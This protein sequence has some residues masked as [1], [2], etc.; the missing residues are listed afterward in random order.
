MKRF[1][2]LLPK[3]SEGSP[4]TPPEPVKSQPF[5]KYPWRANRRDQQRVREA[6]Q[7]GQ[8]TEA[9]DELLG[10]ARKHRLKTGW[11]W[12]L[13]IGPS[14]CREWLS[15][16]PAWVPR[17]TRGG[18]SWPVCRL[19]FL[20][21]RDQFTAEQLSK[22][23][24]MPIE[25]AREKKAF[26]KMFRNSFWRIAMQEW[27]YG[28]QEIALTIREPSEFTATKGVLKEALAGLNEDAGMIK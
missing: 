2:R 14:W 12:G 27:K 23:L 21:R 4:E 1:K 25:D 5:A 10:F 15:A 9:L 11:H 24:G 3:L 20:A 22:R 19:Y 6:W 28:Y 17:G 7:G 8:M 26:P 13:V 18:D 16:K